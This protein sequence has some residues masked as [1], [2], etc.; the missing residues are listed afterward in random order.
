MEF[1]FFIGFNNFYYDI[2]NSVVEL[3]IKFLLYQFARALNIIRR[4]SEVDEC[5]AEFD[6]GEYC[7]R[8]EIELELILAVTDLDQPTA[9]FASSG[10]LTKISG[11]IGKMVSTARLFSQFYFRCRVLPGCS[12]FDGTFDVKLDSDL[13]LT[14]SRIFTV[15]IF[16]ERFRVLLNILQIKPLLA[17]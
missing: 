11:L 10:D 17:M 9:E 15:Q 4:V 7:Y 2:N 3:V 1:K 5:L 12:G 14:K 8:H 6:S 13:S 16:I